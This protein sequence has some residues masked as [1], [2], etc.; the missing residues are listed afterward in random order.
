MDL[1]ERCD[2]DWREHERCEMDQIGPQSLRKVKQGRSAGMRTTIRCI[3]FVNENLG[4]LA[5]NEH[6]SWFVGIK[7]MYR[8]DLGVKDSCMVADCQQDSAK[9]PEEP[10]CGGFG[11]SR[12]KVFMQLDVV[13][14][15]N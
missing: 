14:I 15:T 2:L 3:S 4:F 12:V 13:R 7:R 10:H 1:A 6:L 8:R 11:E 5:Q 9:E